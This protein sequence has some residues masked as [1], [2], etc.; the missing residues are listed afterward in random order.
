MIVPEVAVAKCIKYADMIH[1]K[2]FYIRKK[3]RMLPQDGMYTAGAKPGEAARN[4]HSRRIPQD[5]AEPG[6]CRHRQRP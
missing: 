5:A 1:L 2:D 4:A 3:D 6:L